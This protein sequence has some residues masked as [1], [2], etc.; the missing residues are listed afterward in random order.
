MCYSMHGEVGGLPVGVGS[1]LL[2][3]GLNQTR[4]VKLGSKHRT[5]FIVPGNK[6]LYLVI[7][8]HVSGK[9]LSSILSKGIKMLL[10]SVFLEIYVYVY[11]HEYMF[12]HH[13]CASAYRNQKRVLVLL[14]Q[15]LQAVVNCLM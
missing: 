15:E 6:F 12:V 1:L 3:C 10:P 13:A 7:M 11:V 8:Y 2:L 9:S 4:I 14:E 5:H